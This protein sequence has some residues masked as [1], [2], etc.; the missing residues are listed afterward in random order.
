MA[1]V[2]RR[3][4]PGARLAEGSSAELAFVN[5][6][7][8][9]EKR[10]YLKYLRNRA[11]TAFR[12]LSPKSDVRVWYSVWTILFGGRGKMARASNRLTAIAVARTTKPGF[13][14]DGHSLYLRI[15][16]T[17]S[18][19]WVFRYRLAG[20]LHDMGLGPLHTVSLA[21]ARSKALDLRRQRLDGTDPLTVKR[22]AAA[23][24]D[25]TSPSR[26]RRR[27]LGVAT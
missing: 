14:A 9:S 16:P 4:P 2:A 11:F 19:S 1:A 22:E 6:R 10:R 27:P 13:Y 15:G 18:K 26:K 20:R 25:A 8:R 17:G 12:L 21:D 23:K 24:D 7:I 3:R 5:F